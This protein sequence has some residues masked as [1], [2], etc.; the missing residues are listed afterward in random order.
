MGK[1]PVAVPC[2][3]GT[4]FSFFPFVFF[5]LCFSCVSSPR[6]GFFSLMSTSVSSGWLTLLNLW[7]AA[8]SCR[9]HS[10]V[11][12]SIRGGHF[13]VYQ[14]VCHLPLFTLLCSTSC[15][16]SLR[17]RLIAGSPALLHSRVGGGRG[18]TV[19]GFGSLGELLLACCL[20][21][22]RSPQDSLVEYCTL[23]A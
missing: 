17:A 2:L 5:S 22:S 13:T 4:L 21:R 15:E 20:S 1:G 14:S 10:S 9:F 18:G 11:H 3:G 6:G 12:P 16:L 8:Y 7:F 23:H 19:S